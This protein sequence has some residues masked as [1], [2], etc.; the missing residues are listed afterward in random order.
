MRFALAAAAV[1]SLVPGASASASGGIGG[2]NEPAPDTTSIGESASGVWVGAVPAG[3]HVAVSV[4][5]ARPGPGG[6]GGSRP[7]LRCI[8]LG[9]QVPVQDVFVPG[10]LV[11]EGWYWFWCEQAN[12]PGVVVVPPYRRQYLPPT[13]GAG[14]GEITAD[15]LV[16]PA[17]D[18]LPLVAPIVGA[19]PPGG[20]LYVNV[21]TYLAVTNP[22][23]DGAT[24]LAQPPGVNIWAHAEARLMSVVFD[25]G[26]GD[27][28]VVCDGWGNL[29][30]PQDPD[31]LP[32]CGYT[33][34]RAGEFVVSATVS[35]EITFAS[36]DTPPGVWGTINRS[37][38]FPV[39]VLELEVVVTD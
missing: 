14:G 17:V 36:S 16:A 18:A 30:D 8:W 3:T 4:G 26:N 10:A 2:Q 25:P 12:A 9:G 20:R 1:F 31:R 7:P 29:F 35:W 21:P 28:L 34:L 39:E 32:E 13:G 15:E 38:T 5:G 6:V 19:S 27:E 24:A 23:G 33:Y 11:P 37:G 22:N